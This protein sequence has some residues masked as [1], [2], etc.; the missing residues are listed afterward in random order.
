MSL[1]SSDNSENKSTQGEPIEDFDALLKAAFEKEKKLKQGEVVPGK[2]I[3]V[4]DE[5]VL[6]DVNFKAEGVVGLEEFEKDEDGKYQVQPGDE[7][8][9]YIQSLEGADGYM[10][11]SKEQADR[12]KVWDEV[13][14]VY[15]RGAI[16]EGT[17][18]DKV[19]GGLVVD[20]GVKGFLPGSQIGLVPTKD[21]DSF[22]NQTLRCRVIKFNK[23][24]GNVVLS[25]R[26]VLEEERN[27][28]KAVTLENL[29]E[30]QIVDGIIKNV[31]DYGVFVDLGGIDGLLHVTDI[32][33]GRAEN[34]QK[35]FRVGDP[36]RVQVLKYDREKQRVSLGMKQ[37]TEDPWST[38]YDKY[39]PGSVVEGK[40]VSL[41]NYGAFISL[42]DGVEGLIHVSEMSW[43]K[44]VKH[45]NK[46]LSPDQELKAKVLEVDADN[47]KISLGLKQLEENP[48]EALV[49]K[50]PIGSTLKGQVSNITDF[51][52][53][54]TVEDGIDGLVHVSDIA[55]GSK[56]P[57]PAELFQREQEIEAK[58]LHIDVENE[59]FSLGI[60]QLSEDPWD[61]M[62]RKFNVG[63]KVNGKVARITDFGAFVEIAPDVEGLVHISEIADEK[64]DDIGNYLQEGQELEVEIT[65]IDA[66]DRKISLSIKAL[67]RRERDKEVKKYMDTGEG[68]S[69]SLADA[70]KKNSQ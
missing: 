41:T 34:P 10:E 54:V 25:R 20:I 9:V 26:A 8:L 55:W 7:L 44:K 29:D 51:G 4:E 48:W 27:Q 15:E 69:S 65:Q 24:R 22:L 46:L 39:P 33:W 47:K 31:T 56:S 1:K 36:I 28:L 66:K 35:T 16:I 6:V 63:T 67:K 37:M 61:K 38:V 60:K 32:S 59:K 53:F 21:L 5:F 49:Y 14:E 70:F 13:A 50:Y 11:L 40:V 18:V 23:R 43:N 19:R 30:G 42:E 68:L 3:S 52:L 2:V 45:P 17:V 64:V 57:N 12:L 62:Q 58:V